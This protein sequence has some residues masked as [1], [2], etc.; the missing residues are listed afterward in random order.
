KTP[1][2][3]V[4]ARSNAALAL[5]VRRASAASSA[6]AFGDTSPGSCAPSAVDVRKPS[7]AI[8]TRRVVRP[9]QARSDIDQLPFRREHRERTREVGEPLR[10]HAAE[11]T[12]ARERDRERDHAERAHEHERDD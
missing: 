11:L 12:H 1:R 3:S 5:S 7:A 10:D 2:Y 4:D 9:P 6:R 8:D